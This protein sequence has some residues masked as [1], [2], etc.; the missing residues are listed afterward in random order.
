MSSKYSEVWNILKTTGFVRLAVLAHQQNSLKRAI[1]KRKY[2][3][4]KFKYEISELNKIAY[5]EFQA[6]GNIL[7]VTLVIKSNIWN[8]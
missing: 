6:T 7:E 1:K 4:L 2:K 8:I 3:D 5:L